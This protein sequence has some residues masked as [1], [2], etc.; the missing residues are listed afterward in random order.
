M[1]ESLP[2]HTIMYHSIQG[3]ENVLLDS[4]SPSLMANIAE[5]KLKYPGYLHQVKIIVFQ[6]KE[7]KI[8]CRAIL[9]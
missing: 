3:V 4:N 8:I 6:S 1:Q 2:V 5:S 7:L 9:F